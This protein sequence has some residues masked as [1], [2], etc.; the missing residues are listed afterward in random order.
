MLLRS[1]L[2][3][4]KLVSVMEYS[5][6]AH[7]IYNQEQTTTKKN[8]ECIGSRNSIWQRESK[9]QLQRSSGTYT[10]QNQ[11]RQAYKDCAFDLTVVLSIERDCWML[12]RSFLSPWFQVSCDSTFLPPLN[13]RPWVYVLNVWVYVDSCHIWVT[14]SFH[15]LT[16]T[17]QTWDLEHNITATMKCHTNRTHIGVFRIE[18]TGN[19]SSAALPCGH[20]VLT[21]WS[22]V[23][24]SEY[25]DFARSSQHRGS[26]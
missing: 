6:C 19:N 8:W 9:N 10:A 14:K 2:D 25:L 22:E 24:S 1:R 15:A 4:C 18:M 20:F 12:I 7:I 3:D 5:C 13:S 23:R 11:L 26:L 17:S 21:W 16:V